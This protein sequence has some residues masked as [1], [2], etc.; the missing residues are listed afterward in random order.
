MMIIAIKRKTHLLLY[1]CLF[2]KTR[3]DMLRI[4][5]YAAG[6]SALNPIEHLWSICSSKLTSVQLDSSVREDGIPPCKD[7]SL[8]E[9]ERKDQEKILLERGAQD[10]SAYWSELTFDGHAVVPV[11]VDC[12]GRPGDFL[13]SASEL[14]IT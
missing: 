3:L 10:I 11:P 14:E 12:D 2:K 4:I 8:D 1:A 7:T 9:E 5:R 13:K 6:W